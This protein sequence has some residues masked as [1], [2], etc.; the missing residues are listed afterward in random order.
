MRT[1]NYYSVEY[2]AACGGDLYS[3]ANSHGSLSTVAGDYGNEKTYWPLGNTST[4]VNRISINA[5]FIK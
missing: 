5:V 1:V 4:G 3:S 2:S